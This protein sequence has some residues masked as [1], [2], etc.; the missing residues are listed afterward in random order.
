MYYM[1]HIC[2][3]VY[4]HIYMYMYIHPHI[5]DVILISDIHLGILSHLCIFYSFYIGYI[6][7]KRK[8]KFYKLSLIII[9]NLMDMLSM[10]K[11]YILTISHKDMFQFSLQNLYLGLQN[12]LKKLFIYLFLERGKGGRKSE[13]HQCV[14][15]ISVG[16][17]S[18]A[19]KR[20]MAHPPPRHVPWPG[21]EPASFAVVG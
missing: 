3:Y 20:N 10:T 1:L 6:L 18:R 7:T 14:R 17:L 16:Y 13:S 5:L 19:P 2:I 9:S 4:T 8:F 12:I 15:E 11:E 21:I